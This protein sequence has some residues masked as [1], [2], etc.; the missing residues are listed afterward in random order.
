MSKVIGIIGNVEVGK[1]SLAETVKERGVVMVDTNTESKAFK[2]ENVR[3]MTDEI[4]YSPQLKISKHHNRKHKN[5]RVKN[6]I[7]RKSRKLNR[8]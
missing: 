8:K 4:I 3:G 5:N 1:A 6:R 7:A 2:I